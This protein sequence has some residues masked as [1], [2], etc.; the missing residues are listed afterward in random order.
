MITGSLLK[1]KV[2]ILLTSGAS[3]PD[4][5]VEGILLRLLTFFSNARDFDDVM[6][7]FQ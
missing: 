1:E 4:T 2:I 6:H 3:C 7:R 5:I